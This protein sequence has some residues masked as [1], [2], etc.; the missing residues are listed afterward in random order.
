MLLGRIEDYGQFRDRLRRGPYEFMSDGL[1]MVVI[2]SNPTPIRC[3]WLA[4]PIT[5]PFSTSFFHDQE[6]AAK[7]DTDG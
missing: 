6:F 7:Y 3:S 4:F 1:S 2:T 5:I